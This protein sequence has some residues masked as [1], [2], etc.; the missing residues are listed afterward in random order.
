VDGG[1]G[2]VIGGGKM[3]QPQVVVLTHWFDPTADNVIRALGKRGADVFRCDAADFPQRLVMTAA[4]EDGGWAGH[5]R[6]S[7]Y[8]IRL[9][10]VT[11][12]YYRRPSRPEFAAEMTTAEREWAAAEARF[13]F[14]GLVSAA[15]PWLNHPAA[16]ARA[17]YKPVQLQEAAQAGLSVPETLLTNDPARAARFCSEHEDRVVYKS[18]SGELI[19]DG[20][21]VK[22][23]YTTPVDAAGAGHSSV[24]ATAHLFQRQVHDKACDVRV[25]AVDT[26]LFAVAIHA[27]SPKGR[28]DWRR[29]Y[30]SHTYEVVSVPDR[31]RT[32]IGVLMRRLGLRF[33]A[34]DFVVQQ[35][36]DWLFLEVNPNGQWGF[37]EDATG[38]P[39]A[40]AIAEALIRTG[41][42]DGSP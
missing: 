30:D 12:A 5:L 18:L 32:G 24:A 8:S 40:D 1:T 19:A 14:G 38:L 31:V 34:L 41:E 16:M 28:V 17:E 29:D 22:A 21:D 25:T 7:H 11:G 20:V 15:L 26:V 35:D 4:L 13:G 36:G 42:H 39:V 9:R 3:S 37:I 33:G 27:G 10:E 6:T 2:Q 23:V